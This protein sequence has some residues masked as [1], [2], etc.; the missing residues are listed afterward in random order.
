[1]IDTGNPTV[2]S[3][4]LLKREAINVS[5]LSYKPVIFRRYLTVILLYIEKSEYLAKIVI[6]FLFFNLANFNISGHTSNNFF[7]NLLVS[8]TSSSIRVYWWREMSFRLSI[9]GEGFSI[10]E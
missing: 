5:D 4:L 3:Q 10:F 6:S 1:M 2:D 8:L 9:R 7:L